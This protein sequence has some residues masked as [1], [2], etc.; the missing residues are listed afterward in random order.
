MYLSFRRIQMKNY[1]ILREQL[2]YNNDRN[3]MDGMK[4]QN[5][6]VIVLDNDT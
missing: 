1:N 5:G 2:S 3:G 4:A 6:L